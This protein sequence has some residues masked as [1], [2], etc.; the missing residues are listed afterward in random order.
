MS[1]AAAGRLSKRTQASTDNILKYNEAYRLYKLDTGGSKSE[2]K[3][4]KEDS[5]NDL[6]CCT[7]PSKEFNKQ[8]S[9]SSLINVPPAA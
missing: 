5:S 4:F 9:K 8:I 3:K 7:N 1:L 6:D 2:Y